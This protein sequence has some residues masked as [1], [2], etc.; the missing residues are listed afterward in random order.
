LQYAKSVRSG[1]TLIELIIVIVIVGI[2]AMAAIPKYFANIERAR[3]AEATSSMS[4]IRDTL[5][6]Y[7]S[8]YGVYP[9]DDTFPIVVVVEGE[10]I[11]T[12]A[13]PSSGNFTFGY[14]SA[15]IT[16]THVGGNCDYTMNIASGAI[17]E[18]CS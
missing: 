10:T 1:F 15:T 8:V 4:A 17:G 3:K 2:L 11:T 9:A 6:S 14:N 12:V 16:A 18:V 7:K 13:Q 5:Q